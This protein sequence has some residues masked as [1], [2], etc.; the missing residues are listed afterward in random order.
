[1]GKKLIYAIELNLGRISLCITGRL[2]ISLP[3][4]PLD[5]CENLECGLFVCMTPKIKQNILS[6]AKV[7]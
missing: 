6:D 3:R 4:E 2:L 7:E 5:S 1:M